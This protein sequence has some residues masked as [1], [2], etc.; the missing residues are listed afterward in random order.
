LIL[1]PDE[2]VIK[3][4]GTPRHSGRYPYG[5]GGD[6]G[7]PNDRR[8]FLDH[9]DALKK[10]GLT[11][12]QIAKGMGLST[13]ELRAKKSIAKNEIR[14]ADASRAERL[15]AE[16]YSNV[17][18]GKLMNRPESSVRA[19]LAEGV[20]EK[21]N[22]LNTIADILA[23]NVEK[24]QFV[25]VGLGVELHMGISKEKLAN[26]VAILKEK[27][28]S[29]EKVK[30]DQLGTGHQ[31]EFKILAPPGFTQKDIW[32]QRDKIKQIDMVRDYSEDGGRTFVGILPPLSVSSK[33]VAV[34]YKEDGGEAADGVIYVRPGKSDI[35]LGK[36]NYAQVRVAVDGTHYLKG[37]A[38][39]KRDLPPG[40]DLM[41][42]TNKSRADI[43][44]NKLSAMKKMK[45][46]PENPFGAVVR[47]I[48]DID[49]KGNPRVTSAMNLVN[50]E[51]DWQ[52]WS[53]N[54]SSQMLSKQGHRLAKEQLDL[55]YENKKK[56]FDEIMALTNPTVKQ[57]LLETFAE[58]ADSSA[59]NLKAAS[60][61]R[62][63][64]HV[65]L[66][67]NSLKDN[68]IYAPNY[69]SGERV[70]LVRYPHG[71]TFEIP[72]LVVN[73]NHPPSKK[74]LGNAPDA[75]G[76]NS[77]VAARLSG[78]D[79]DGDT[80]L[81]IP[82]DKRKV[83]TS[84]PL[85]GLKNFDP[86]D[87]Y[88]AYE[89]MPKMTAQQKA[90]EMGYVSNLIT[91]MTIAGASHEELARA[92]RHS[93]VVIDAE[94]HN[95]NYKQSHKDNGI[96][97]LMLKYQGRTQ[98]GASTLISRA[99]SDKRVPDRKP[100]P[101]K[102]GGAID[103]KTGRRVYVLSGKTNRDGSLKTVKSTKLAETDD[104]FTLVSKTKPTIVE[105]V[106][107]EHSNRMKA[108]ANESRKQSLRTESIRYSKSAKA[109]YASQV[110]TLNAKLNAAYR[111]KP[112][113]RQAQLLA[114]TKVAMKRR[115]NPDMDK[116]EIK[117]LK[118][119]A[120]EEARV[121]MG[122]EK[123]KF[124]IED[125]EW[126]AIQAGAITPSKLR[127][128]LDNADIDRVKELATPKPKLLMTGVKKRRAQA[129]LAGGATQAEVASA[130]GVSLTTLKTTLNG[131][132]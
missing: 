24:Q 56:A 92:V 51:G 128:M 113:E 59:V 60:M 39:Y 9:V 131:E 5:S 21:A 79:F 29:V 99:T 38:I 100:R 117:K 25:D 61:P 73:N 6:E 76:I 121:N 83:T 1:N 120:L 98:G 114:T 43:G 95:L 22:S 123:Q 14:A 75:V 10:Q 84:S 81:V 102:D 13:T 41:F 91:D 70:V 17:D 104:A 87:R 34:R 126:A 32:L 86:Q 54:L 82:N 18:I 26:A 46:D 11:E 103:P 119:M 110:D 107:A 89:G 45:D 63:A 130:L 62:Q 65:I 8:S 116:A 19:L 16:G 118:S 80:V 49:S 124:R 47:Q 67:V 90:S 40:V 23:K 112:L 101:A 42:N 50:E 71:G 31:T 36:N 55:A 58:E 85:E 48:K 2:N 72:E 3:H 64:T 109:A 20:K 52:K 57:K 44:D 69:N 127:N 28:Y 77:K 96:G 115:A 94:K 35:S 68:E 37:M 106:Y 93:M 33:R 4:Y 129:M 122:A 88:K 74:L 108:L 132:D 27:G 78:A 12:P 30:I 53:K 111:N 125:D 7:T 66:P 97:A 105:S 15:R